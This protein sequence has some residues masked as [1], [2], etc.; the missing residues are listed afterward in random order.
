MS[1]SDSDVDLC[2]DRAAAYKARLRGFENQINLEEENDSCSSC[3]STMMTVVIPRTAMTSSDV[4]PPLPMNA[5]HSITDRQSLQPQHMGCSCR[6]EFVTDLAAF[7][8]CKYFL[9]FSERAYDYL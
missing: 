6:N 7:D 3:S 1:G 9:F 2:M 8:L 4:M 5:R